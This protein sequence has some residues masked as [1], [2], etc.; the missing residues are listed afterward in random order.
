M[1]DGCLVCGAPIAELSGYWG[2]PNRT[3]M[4]NARVASGFG[5]FDLCW[6]CWDGIAEQY[7]ARP[8]DFAK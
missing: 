8:E 6:P 7:E 1:E 5:A 3:T 4:F 2:E